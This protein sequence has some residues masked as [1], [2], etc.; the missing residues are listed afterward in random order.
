MGVAYMT[1]GEKILSLRTG[2]GMSQD[3]LAEALGVSRQAV[4]KW[5]RDEA[6]PDIENIV[7]ISNH[8]GVSTDYLIK[9]D[10]GR[11]T[12]R[13]Q[14]KSTAADIFDS[15]GGFIKKKWY[16]AGWILVAKGIINIIQI[17]IVML[18]AYFP[19]LNTIFSEPGIY[20]AGSSFF[21][22]FTGIPFIPVVLG[23]LYIAAGL[24]VLHFGKRYCKRWE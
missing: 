20:D 8:F 13:P 1:L 22:I 23:L 14:P 10:S 19:M 16:L 9:P 24:C 18:M 2:R 12:C 11:K 7:K 3:D 21:S 5:E 4:S 15:I 6:V 17:C